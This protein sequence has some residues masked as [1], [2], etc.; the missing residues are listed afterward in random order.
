MFGR[1]GKLPTQ[2]SWSPDST[3]K[4]ARTQIQEGFLGALLL[5]RWVGDYS[6]TQG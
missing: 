1:D 6:L 4:E 5:P 2:G 3:D